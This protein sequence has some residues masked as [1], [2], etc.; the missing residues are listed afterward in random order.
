MQIW[1]RYVQ[2]S[3]RTKPW[4][5]TEWSGW[6]GPACGTW[7]KP[8]PEPG[9]D[10]LKCPVFFRERSVYLHAEN[11]LLLISG[12]LVDLVRNDHLREASVSERVLY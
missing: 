8:R 4:N 1:S 2:K 10:C 11:G 3:A 12:V 9:L 5:S 7:L 6:R